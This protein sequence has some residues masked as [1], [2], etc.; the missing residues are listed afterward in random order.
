MNTPVPAPD[1]QPSTQP[2]MVKVWDVLV[3]L[4]HWSLVSAVLLA[5]VQVLA[6]C[7]L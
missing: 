5:W 7:D 2:A 6:L 4:L 1:A 3:R